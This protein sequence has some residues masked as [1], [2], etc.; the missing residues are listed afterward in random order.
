MTR[1]PDPRPLTSTEQGL[2]EFLL[3]VEFPGRAELRAQVESVQAAGACDCGCG[4]LDLAVHPS[5]PRSSCRE[6]IPIEAYNATT[7]VLLFV[8]DG[9]LS[10]IEVVPCGG[11]RHPAPYPRPE[12]LTLWPWRGRLWPDSGS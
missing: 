2:L 9:R 8:R 6:P 10:R 11:A 12:D 5:A 4:T 3:S 7:E 1:F